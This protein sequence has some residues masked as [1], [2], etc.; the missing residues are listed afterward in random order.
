MRKQ[1]KITNVTVYL[2]QNTKILWH[3][4][5]LIFLL[6][7]RRPF[8]AIE[9]FQQYPCCVI[10]KLDKGPTVLFWTPCCAC[11]KGKCKQ[12]LILLSLIQLKDSVIIFKSI[13]KKL[14]DAV[15][16]FNFNWKKRT[17]FHYLKYYFC[18]IYLHL[19]GTHTSIPPF[20][21]Q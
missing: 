20:Q 14:M 3:T 21:F 13:L 17:V 1:N 7:T 8:N 6:I 4:K 2:I 12:I 16:S 15:K 10:N 19:L 11:V 9:R 18:F 5:I